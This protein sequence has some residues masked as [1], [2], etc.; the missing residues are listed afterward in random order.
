MAFYPKGFDPRHIQ[1]R[2]PAWH[3]PAGPLCPPHLTAMLGIWVLFSTLA[4]A[5][6][7]PVSESFA[8][9]IP[10]LLEPWVPWVLEEGTPGRD[11]RGCPLDV[12]GAMRLCAWPGLLELEIAETGGRFTQDWSLAA[13][14]WVW[15]PGDEE[16]WPE[17]VQVGDRAGPVVMRDGRPAVWLPA[18]QYRLSG[19]LIWRTPPESLPVPPETGWVSLVQGQAGLRVV[20]P[21]RDGR[22]WLREPGQ[23]QVAEQE[24]LELR[25]YRLIEDDLPLRVLTRLELSISRRAREVRLGPV[26]L[27]GGIP[28]DLQ[29]PLPA[30]LEADGTLRVQVRP[31]RWV[32]KVASQHPGRVERLVCPHLEA[33][34][35]KREVWAFVAHPERRR[36]EPFGLEPLDPTQSGVPAEWA[37]LP[38]YAAEPNQTLNFAEIGRGDPD[39][40]PD[41]LQLMR[42][43]WLDFTGRGLSIR[44]RLTGTL[45]RSWRLEVRPGLE[46]GQVRLDDQPMLITRLGPDAPPGIEVR[47]SRGLELVADS[48]LDSDPNWIPASGWALTLDGTTARLN[49]PP[50]WDVLAAFGADNRPDTWLSRWTLL[51]LFL[52]LVIAFGIGRLWGIVWGGGALIALVLIWLEPGA[53]HLVWLHLLA[54]AALLRLLPEHPET[55]GLRRWRLAVR[56]YQRLAFLALLIIGLPF[57]VAEV[58]AGLYPQLAEPK[59]PAGAYRSEGAMD[60]A[61]QA[62]AIGASRPAEALLEDGM[63]GSRQTPPIAPKPLERLDPKALIQTGPGVPNWHWRSIELAWSGP[64]DTEAGARLWLL[65]P[66]MNLVR[67]WAGAVLLV[68]LSIRLGGVNLRP[69]AHVKAKRGAGLP[70]A[71]IGLGLLLIG[72]SGIPRPAM[73]EPL[74]AQA[75]P[76]AWA[77]MGAFPSPELLKELRARLLRPPECLPNCVSLASL[78]IRVEPLSDQ[79][80]E[81]LT[82]DLGLDAAAH[83]AAPLLDG[84]S[85]WLPAQVILDGEALNQLRRDGQGRLVIPLTPGRHRVQMRGPV[86]HTTLSAAAQAD[87]IDLAFALR[88]HRVEAVAEGWRIEGLNPEGRPGAQFQL[89]RLARSDATGERPLFQEALPPLLFIERRLI[90]GFDWRVETRVR[91]LSSPDFPILVQVPLIP[92]ESVQTL[93]IPIENG[94]AQVALAPGQLELAWSGGLEPISA[95]TLTASTD[96]SLSESWSLDL[97]PIWHLDG[98]DLA[99]IHAQGQGEACLTQWRPLPGERLNLR[100]SRPEAVPGPTL[101]LDRVIFELEP[102]QRGTQATLTL[103]ARSTQ[104]GVYGLRLP[105]DAELRA[106]S[107]DGR[108]LPLPATR[109]GRIELPLVPGDQ[110]LRAVWRSTRPLTLGFSPPQPDLGQNAVNIHQH[111][112]LPADRWV[113]WVWGPGMGPAILFWGLLAVVFGLALVLGRLRL[114]PLRWYDWLLLGLGLVLSEVWVGL[115]VAGWLLAL[116]WRGR[117]DPNQMHWWRFNL[118]QI[119]LVLLTLLAVSALIG[120]VKQGLLGYPEMWVRGQGSSASLLNWY[121]DRGGPLL[122]QIWVISAPLWVYRALMLAWA[123]WLAVHLLDW[124]RWGFL[125]FARPSPWLDRPRVETDSPAGGQT[126]ELR[127][128]GLGGPTAARCS[129][130]VPASAHGAGSGV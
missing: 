79:A 53:P 113:L 122:P 36:I 16:L 119:G 64:V 125:G 9:S 63:G 98:M 74:G 107:A 15:L 29:S 5:Q 61:L 51:D 22:L 39:P 4:A 41:R 108:D 84:Q 111:L 42:E 21:D 57:L 71:Q 20:Q 14:A 85:G 123:L 117:L 56:W 12:Q 34:W 124:L 73:A 38:V 50:G 129:D 37:R 93:G 66:P 91:R 28:Y 75:D 35:P 106:L 54:A 94:R 102:S 116:G 92:G 110:T 30:R 46:L 68:M 2:W 3:S 97:S 13:P 25:V 101:T 90:L 26:L 118:L 11:Q 49:L 109:T 43:L 52:V 105:A 69:A 115:L 87:R 58:R 72:A 40:E 88:P 126:D 7:A 112:H 100:I 32:L 59:A 24:G 104:G 76:S 65:T 127:L 47:P 17:A 1:I 114:T 8:P 31:G 130:T 82:L 62:P 18:G 6:P 70:L 60:K 45:S 27:A 128:D 48:R 81:Q 44:D 103:S 89:I 121:Q 95:L 55:A 23:T 19:R 80:N 83:V 120:A 10:A 99:P 96:P 86:G 78:A 33:P 77:Q 67:A